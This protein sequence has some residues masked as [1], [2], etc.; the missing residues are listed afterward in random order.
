MKSGTLY[1]LLMLTTAGEIRKETLDCI[2]RAI[3]LGELTVGAKT[4]LAYDIW[5]IEE[6]S[7]E[8]IHPS[9]YP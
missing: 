9:Y 3:F 8:Y 4:A 2:D 6:N 7:R 1:L 5:K